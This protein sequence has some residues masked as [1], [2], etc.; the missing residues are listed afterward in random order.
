MKR[1]EFLFSVGKGIVFSCA[2]A[3][4]LAACSSDSG[5]TDPGTN[6]GNNG[7]SANNKISIP[8]TDIPT[9]GDQKVKSGV[10]FIRLG[11]GSTGSDFLATEAMCPHQGGQLVYKEN[12]DLIECQLHSAQYEIDGDTIRGPQ[13]SSGSTRDLKI[14][15]LTVSDG[16]ITATKA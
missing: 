3:C 15:A 1:K 10:L 14:Y 16:M 8:V 12:E 2:G 6:S 13:N 9:I 4:A 11:E 7:G 5:S